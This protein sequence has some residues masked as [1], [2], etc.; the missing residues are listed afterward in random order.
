MRFSYVDAFDLVLP[1]GGEV[2]VDVRW[3]VEVDDQ[4]DPGDG[5]ETPPCHSVEFATKSCEV[6]AVDRYDA[7][8]FVIDRRE[9]EGGTDASQ[10]NQQVADWCPHSVAELA[11]MLQQ[12][13]DLQRV[14]L[15]YAQ[16][17]L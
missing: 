11:V 12:S 7:G 6:L 9:F 13:I 5:Y 17:H 3:H 10:F 8:G 15:E 4:S 1:S 14:H 16:S 2:C